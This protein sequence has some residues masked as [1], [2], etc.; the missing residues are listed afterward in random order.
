MDGETAPDWSRIPE[1]KREMVRVRWQEAHTIVTPPTPLYLW[2]PQIPF[3]Q[4]WGASAQQPPHYTV[5]IHDTSHTPQDND[6]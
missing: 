6:T 2:G 5:T 3:F 4:S 1:A